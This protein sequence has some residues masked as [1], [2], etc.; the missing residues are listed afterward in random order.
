MAGQV[1]A[2]PE[3]MHTMSAHLVVKGADQ[4]IEFYKKAFGAQQR[5]GIFKGPDGKVV[6]A[7]LKIGDSVF[8][9]ADEFPT[10]S[11]CQ[12]PQTLGGTSVVLNVYVDNVDKLFDQAVSA[13]AKVFMP[14]ANQFWG[15]R[16]GQVSDPF[17]HRWALGQHV[18]EVAPAEME[19]RGKEFFA[20][21][22]QGQRA[23]G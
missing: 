1:K 11:G 2:V 4:A 19:R 18:E 5:G 13:G 10:S 20:K 23:S 8:M 9:L 3:G 22:A 21:M 6:H 15:D 7:E 12:S 17:G 14:L 16:Y